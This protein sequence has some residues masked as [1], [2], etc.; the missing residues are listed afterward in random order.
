MA[1]VRRGGVRAT[2]YSPTSP[3]SASTS[4]SSAR[5]ATTRRLR[6][7]GFVAGTGND[8]VNIAMAEHARHAS[9]D[10]YLVV[11]QQTNAI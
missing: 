3:P 9:P 5:P 8:T 11:R 7:V 6:A 4:T 1:G 2:P 10:A